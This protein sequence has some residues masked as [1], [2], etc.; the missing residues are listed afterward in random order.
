MTTKNKKDKNE[1]SKTKVTKK[2]TL[3]KFEFTRLLSARASELEAGSKPKIPMSVIT[4]KLGLEKGK[5][6]SQDYVKI[7]KEEFYQDKIE[8]EVKK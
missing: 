5:I 6:L 8:L 7:A 1:V 2:G 4:E 3:S